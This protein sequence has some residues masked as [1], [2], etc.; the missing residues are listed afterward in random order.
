MQGV[1]FHYSCCD[2]LLPL[3]ISSPKTL[4]KPHLLLS[5]K[6]LSDIAATS[7]ALELSSLTTYIKKA[8]LF[9]FDLTLLIQAV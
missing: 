6:S 4:T 7:L 9:N 2:M 3:Q 1:W 8:A 5:L